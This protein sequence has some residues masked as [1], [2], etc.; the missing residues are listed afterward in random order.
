MQMHPY[1]EY[2]LVLK[3]LEGTIS[4]IQQHALLPEMALDLGL[5]RIDSMTV[6]PNPDQ[7]YQHG[8]ILAKPRLYLTLADTSEVLELDLERI[9]TYIQ[10]I[11]KGELD[12][13][14]SPSDL[15]LRKWVIYGIDGQLGVPHLVSVSEP[16]RFQYHADS[17][18]PQENLKLVSTQPMYITH[19]N[20]SYLT[21]IDL[22]DQ[23]PSKILR[24]EDQF[25]CQD[26]YLQGVLPPSQASLTCEDQIDNDQNNVTDFEDI[27]CLTRGYES[28]VMGCPKL[29][30]SQMQTTNQNRFAC[31]DA[32]DNDQ[33]GKIDRLDPGCLSELDDHEEDAIETSSCADH[34]DNDQDGLIDVADPDCDFM[35]ILNSGSELGKTLEGQMQTQRWAQLTEN[36]SS[37]LCLDQLDNDFDGATD[38]HDLGCQFFDL[39]Q[40]KKTKQNPVVKPLQLAECL[41]GLDNDQDGQIDLSDIDCTFAQDA[42]ESSQLVNLGFKQII[43]FQ[44][45]IPT[46]YSYLYS[47]ELN[48]NTENRIYPVAY[49]LNA[50]GKLFEIRVDPTN[51]ADPFAIYQF[52]TNLPIQMM[53]IR[54]ADQL[55]S[56]MIVTEDQKLRNLPLQQHAPLMIQQ[57]FKVYAHLNEETETDFKVSAFYV[58]Y[59]Q[60]AYQINRLQ[61]FVGAFPKK[62]GLDETLFI[63]KDEISKTIANLSITEIINDGSLLSFEHEIS[64]DLQVFTDQIRPAYQEWNILLNPAAQL[65]QL[66]VAP[67]LLKDGNVISY[68]PNY[69][70][71]FCQLSVDDTCLIVG[72]SA[73]GNLEFASEKKARTIA[74]TNTYEE[75]LIKEQNPLRLLAGDY[76][77]SFEGRISNASSNSGQWTA[78]AQDRWYLNDDQVDFCQIGVEV[79]DL[80]VADAFYPL[81]QAS[82]KAQECLPFLNLPV[83]IGLFPLRYRVL[84]V[85]AHGLELGVD[86]QSTYENQLPPN[87]FNQFPKIATAPQIPAFRCVAQNI[88]YHIKAGKDQWLLSHSQIGYIHPWL[89][90]AGQCQQDPVALIQKKQSRARFGQMFENQ[91]F[92]FKLGAWFQNPALANTMQGITP[93]T[94]PYMLGMSWSWRVLNGLQYRETNTNI[95]HLQNIK[96]LANL[97]RLYLSDALFQNITE[98][99]N[100]NPYGQ[101]P[102]YL[103]A[104]K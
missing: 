65:N 91:W 12:T 88:S 17:I 28:A 71:N 31:S 42:T 80:W 44:Q 38:I 5:G 14:L 45:R 26:G 32:I 33:D 61:S 4:I 77:L 46:D 58:I 11:Q 99:V 98:L 49:A 9:S 66:S 40:I 84:A 101:T 50:E 16:I 36:G 56:L 25:T 60:T 3:S 81:D 90:V 89:N 64:R 35:A 15:I 70:T 72:Y 2:L 10:Q 27:S 97:D 87:Q 34:L 68:D 92:K 59:D 24:I 18:G 47:G 62:Q 48:T 7:S 21:I 8:Q 37:D 85:H 86:D 23:V 76:T 95:S 6:Y 53:T 51:P 100:L 94:Q 43:G 82:A 20:G 78:I 79:G 74:K 103:Q 22:M 29:S 75:I 96:W 55:S 39:K 13:M 67:I 102:T 93:S 104:F 57:K 19:A 73:D 54:K 41:D 63:V 1:G 52:K 69:H 30:A 83:D